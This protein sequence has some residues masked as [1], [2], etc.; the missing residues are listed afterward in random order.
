MNFKFNLKDIDFNKANPK[1]LHKYIPDTDWNLDQ[2][3]GEQ[4]YVM[5]EHFTSGEMNSYMT[6]NREGKL[7]YD[8]M[9]I[10]K[11]KVKEIHNCYVDGI[12]L[13][14]EQFLAMP[15]SAYGNSLVMNI[16]LHLVNSDS[17]TESEAKN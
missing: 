16:A 15:A 17:L 2:D 6:F 1:L 13:T 9:R 3:E 14:W 11:D 12:E 4:I 8:F 7:S 10:A 5:C